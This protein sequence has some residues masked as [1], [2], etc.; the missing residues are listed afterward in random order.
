MIR[1]L[2]IPMFIATLAP[3]Q[4]IDR[5]VA[6]VNNRV[7][8]QSDWEERAR[9]D[10]FL[11]GRLP[12]SAQATAEILDRLIDMAMVHEQLEVLQYTRN[13]PEEI[14]AQ[15][16][17]IRK[18]L[19][20]KNDAEWRA[21]LKSYRLSEDA[22]R[23]NLADQLD[24]LRFLD[25]RFRPSVQIAPR[26]VEEYFFR[27]LIPDLSAK[28]TPA[29]KLPKLKDVEEQIEKLLTERRLND[30]FNSWLQ[31]LRKQAKIQRF[32]PVK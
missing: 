14:A 7:V 18:Q 27:N 16:M 24:M 11:E 32:A 9:F 28:G 19:G 3:A 31:S 25:V 4:V 12:E 10:A 8:T 2:F 15:T 22:F 21:R 29:E 23:R 6:T 26:E 20:V 1:L 30:L 5:I 17:E 13:S